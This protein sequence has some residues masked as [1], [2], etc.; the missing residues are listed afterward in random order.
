MLI[1]II[2]LQRLPFGVLKLQNLLVAPS[3]P[4][5]RLPAIKSTFF[6]SKVRSRSFSF[7]NHQG[8]ALFKLS[9]AEMRLQ[10]YVTESRGPS[11]CVSRQISCMAAIT[12]CF[13]RTCLVTTEAESYSTRALIGV[14][15]PPWLRFNSKGTAYP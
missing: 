5:H 15:H 4:F 14:N 10:V 11:T 8:S 3:C 2:M 9:L 12:S 6:V 13:S 1:I 7:M